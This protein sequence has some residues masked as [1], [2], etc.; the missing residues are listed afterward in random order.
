MEGLI[1]KMQNL[2]V[3]VLFVVCCWSRVV[4]VVSLEEGKEVESNSIIFERM[5]PEARGFGKKAKRKRC[6]T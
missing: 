6:G 3:C 5:K 4:L 2:P 1:A